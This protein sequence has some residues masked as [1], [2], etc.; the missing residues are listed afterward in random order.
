MK[1]EEQDKATEAKDLGEGRKSCSTPGWA[2]P[3]AAPS[4]LPPLPGTGRAL[5]RGM[6]AVGTLHLTHRGVAWGDLHEGVWM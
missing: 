1:G 6:G 2:L 4:A 3:A 5:S